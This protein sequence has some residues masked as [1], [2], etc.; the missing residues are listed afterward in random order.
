MRHTFA[1]QYLLNGGDL[2]SLQRIMGHSRI[3]ITMDYAAMT[4]TLVASQHEKFSP[5][6][7]VAQPEVAR[8]CE[9]DENE[10]ILSLLIRTKASPRL[11]HS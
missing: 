4:D 3:E 7:N 11:R 9:T 1:V 6:A 10:R 5:M 8:F 2:S